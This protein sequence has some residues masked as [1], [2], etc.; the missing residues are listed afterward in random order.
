MNKHLEVSKIVLIYSVF[1]YLWIFFSDNALGLLFPDSR[2][3][4][5]FAI[6]KGIFFITVTSLLLYILIARFVTRIRQSALALRESEERLNFLIKNTSDYLSIFNGDGRQRYA[7]PA[8][9]KIT[10]YSMDELIGKTIN[11][12]VHPD[13]QRKVMAAWDEAVRFPERTV[14]VQY[15]HVHKT[16]GWVYSEAVAQSFLDRPPINGLVATVR[17]ITERKTAEEA[18]IRKEALLQAMLRNLPFDFWARDT[19]QRLIMQSDES[20]KLWGDLIANQDE[21]WNFDAIT[22]E[23]WRKNNQKVLQGEVVVED[24]SLI[25]RDGTR[26]DFHSL[27][28][29]IREGETILGILGINIDITERNLAELERKALQTQL[30]Q[31]QKM[32]AIGTLAGGIAHDFNNIL[33]AIFG[34]AELARENAPPDSV[35]VRNLN[36]ILEA[37]ERA[38]SLVRQILSFS[39]QDT[40]KR[41]PL[42][43]VQL[44]KE[45]IQLLRPTL[46]STIEIRQQLPASSLLILADPTQIHQ[47]MMNLCTNAFHAMEHGGGILTISVRD[48]ELAQTDPQRYPHVRPGKYVELSISD[49]GVGVPEEI[50]G[51][52]F[53]PYFTTKKVGKGTGMGLAITHGIVTSAGGF[54]TCDSEV[55]KG[56]TFTIFFPAIEQGGQER[57]ALEQTDVQGQGRILFVDDELPLAEMG[58]AMLERLGYTVTVSTGSSEALTIFQQDRDYFDAIITDQTM[59]GMT[60]LDFAKKVLALRP[61]IPIILCTGFSSIVD[62]QLAKECGIQGFVMKPFKREEI[63]V[64][65]RKL[66]NRESTPSV[67]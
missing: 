5:Q 45:A 31:A 50:R 44:I 2:A 17:D 66:L 21:D 59:P 62:E 38:A 24:C 65:L 57:L 55:G 64:L 56:T 34:Y 28:V 7:T 13:D 27:V 20:V 6:F 53:D 47:I 33:G 25:T 36:R 51:K 43:P 12:L 60:G 41:V 63:A 49:T 42:E 54:I 1:G 22:V 32:E 35:I 16:R 15:R 29:P 39:R 4:T 9:E 26:R 30:I 3:L 58:R 48:R 46:P 23:N 52:I 18:L 37:S 67:G 10:G 8:V 11:D 61:D 19:Q 14:T 40:I